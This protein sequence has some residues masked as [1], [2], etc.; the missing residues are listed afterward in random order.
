V[1]GRAARRALRNALRLSR[2]AARAPERFGP[3]HVA[4]LRRTVAM[5]A[6]PLVVAW[7]PAD[8]RGRAELLLA[9]AIASSGGARWAHDAQICAEI[10]GLLLAAADHLVE[11]A[12]A[13]QD[14]RALA[15]RAI[16]AAVAHRAPQPPQGGRIAARVRRGAPG[17][18]A[19]APARIAPARAGDPDDLLAG[20]LE[21]PDVSGRHADRATVRR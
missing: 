14:L 21:A 8:V 10:R 20:E 6:D 19:P 1:V 13:E 16:A 17:R 5:L 18:I 9:R 7:I 12:P 11:P 4:A 2:L 3:R 15:D